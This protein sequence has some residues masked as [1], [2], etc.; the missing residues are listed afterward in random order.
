VFSSLPSDPSL[1]N[2]ATLTNSPFNG[3]LVGGRLD[4]RINQ[5]HT[6]FVRYSIRRL[7]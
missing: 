5:K 1:R 6:A 3:N 2:F 4:W 7:L